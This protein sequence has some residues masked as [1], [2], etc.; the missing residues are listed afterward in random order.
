MRVGV[1]A[2]CVAGAI[3]V[4]PQVEPLVVEHWGGLTDVI[5][6]R[7]DLPRAVVRPDAANL[8]AGPSRTTKVIGKIRR[9]FTVELLEIQDDWV[10]VRAV[11]ESSEQGW[12]H[13][14]LLAGKPTP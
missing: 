14:S 11:G 4:Y 1:A 3:V 9:G 8:R 7:M 12:V 10:L 6:A 13:T 5:S 2:A